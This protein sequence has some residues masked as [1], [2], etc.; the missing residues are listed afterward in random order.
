MAGITSKSNHTVKYPDLSRAKRS[1]PH[2]EELSAPN[3]PEYLTFS[4]N[5]S[6]SGKDHVGQ[7]GGNV[8]CLRNLSK[9]FLI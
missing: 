9:L 5:N 8:E 4:D 6:D 1:V 3:P 2:T 7:E